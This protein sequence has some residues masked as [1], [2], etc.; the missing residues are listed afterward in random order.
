M[1][2]WKEGLAYKPTLSGPIG[3][4]QQLSGQVRASYRSSRFDSSVIKELRWKVMQKKVAGVPGKLMADQIG[5]TDLEDGIKS[6]SKSTIM[7]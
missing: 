7:L 6:K 5:N 1:G 2:T 3:E 4:A